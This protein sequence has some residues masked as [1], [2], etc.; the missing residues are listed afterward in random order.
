MNSDLEGIDD[1]KKYIKT[2][3]V[4]TTNRAQCMVVMLLQWLWA[5]MPIVLL[6]VDIY[7]AHPNKHHAKN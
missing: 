7:G 6:Y 2:N 5:L 3:H 1:K 4:L